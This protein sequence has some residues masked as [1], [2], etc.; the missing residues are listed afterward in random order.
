[1]RPAAALLVFPVLLAAIDQSSIRTHTLSNGMKIIIEEDHD[2]PNVAMY[3]F[4][5]VGSRNER[6]GTTGISHF[7]EHMMFNGAKK[8]GPKQ[9]DI[10][11]EKAGGNNNAYTTQDLT[12][13][14]DWFPKSAMRLMFDMEADRIR[15]LAFDP[16]IIESERGVVA[17]ERLTRTDNS[18]YGLLE[19]QLNAAAYTAH[20]YGWP[21]VGWP[22][23]IKSW[24][25][26][27]LKAHFKM[28]YAPNNCI[29]VVVGDVTGDEVL[30]LAKEFMEPIPRQEPPPPVR[31]VEPPQIG[32][33]RVTITKQS[34]LPFLLVSY[35]IPNKS[36]K[37]MAALEV[38]SA[39]LSEGRS[40]RLYS[41]MV[42]RDQLVLS[43]TTEADGLL[44][45]GQYICYVR[46][47]AGVDVSK[48]EK[49]LFEELEKVRTTEVP[50]DELRK[51]KNQLLTNFY[52]EL[53]T[54]SG[55]ANQLGTAE[56]YLGS[57]QAMYDTPTRY[58]AVTAAD[59][60]RV[61]KQ[62]LGEKQRTIAT[63]IPEVEK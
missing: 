22:S 29:I 45:A 7:F 61:A 49:V 41:R 62:Y 58:E 21:V 16:K 3:L 2:I 40:S 23:D 38:L 17:S 39:I 15:D 8:F 37:D 51:A 34:E 48:A 32:E 47:R 46:P 25:M 55:R 42:D 20:P 9:F 28:G 18:N 57:Y 14:T 33:R 53:K 4:Y 13:Y 52:R 60:L 54:I 30:K 63:L 43:A 27:D 50:A 10:E 31:T 35:H 12:V 26:E 1:M 24:S 11:M 6:P 5:K 56:I 36:H 44:D 19:E 59:V